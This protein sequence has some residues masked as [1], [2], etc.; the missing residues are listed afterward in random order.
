M[1]LLLESTCTKDTVL[2]R[3]IHHCQ[4]DQ[5][6]CRNIVSQ[7]RMAKA[8][9]ET[10]IIPAVKPNENTFNQLLRPASDKCNIFLL[11][12]VAFGIGVERLKLP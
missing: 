2:E 1:K 9:V 11:F 4:I 7:P 12:F 6:R 10:T 5:V 8:F 3:G